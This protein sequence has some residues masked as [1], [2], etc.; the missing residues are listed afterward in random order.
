MNPY[1]HTFCPLCASLS[2][3]AA[4]SMN[5][6][7]ANDV[8]RGMAAKNGYENNVCDCVNLNLNSPDCSDD[9]TEDDVVMSESSEEETEL[10]VP[11]QSIRIGVSDVADSVHSDSSNTSLSIT[12][13]TTD[14]KGDGVNHLST[15][16]PTWCLHSEPTTTDPKHMTEEGFMLLEAMKQQQSIEYSSVLPALSHNSNVPS[17]EKSSSSDREHS[18]VNDSRAEIPEWCLHTYLTTKDPRHM[19][20]EDHMLLAA[21]EQQRNVEKSKVMSMLE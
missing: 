17:S 10:P 14:R 11:E 21:M 7:S 16:I 4:S 13:S 6:V 19:T 9:E 3:V 1:V 20:T 5:G 2:D 18:D 15:E 8:T 12:I